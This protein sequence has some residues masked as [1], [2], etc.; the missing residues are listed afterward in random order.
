MAEDKRDLEFYLNNPEQMPHDL[1]QLQALMAGEGEG[2]D[3]LATTGEEALEKSGAASGAAGKEE[4]AAKSG[5]VEATT[6]KADEES[7]Q[8]AV[9]RSKDGK[10]EIPYTVLQTERE[11]RKAAESA[12]EQMRSRLEALEQQA[13]GTRPAQADQTPQEPDLSDEDMAQIEN[14]FPAIGKLLKGMGAKV[15][16]LTQQLD[17]VRQ[18]EIA[19]RS[20]EATRASTTVQEAIDANDHLTFWQQKD[21]ETFAIAVQ[22]DNQIKADPRNRGLSLDQRFEKVVKAMEAVYG[23]AQLPDEFRRSAPA[24]QAPAAPAPAPRVN[25]KAVADAAQKAI[26]QAQNTSAVRSLSDIPGGVPAESDEITQLGL[27][28]AAD[29]GN[30]FMGMDPAKVMA[31]LARAA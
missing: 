23:E 16:S 2:G 13:K 21:P 22:Y 10:H 19:R 12:L 15:S 7:A 6:A 1:G 8:N 3:E 4:L 31:I 14:D 9:L 20:G 18:S 28:S 30:K 27:M 26:E 17:D 11:Q 5:V 29:L 25:P 24:A